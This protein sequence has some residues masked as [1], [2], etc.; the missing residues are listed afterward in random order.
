MVGYGE[1]FGKI[2]GYEEKPM[3]CIWERRKMKISLKT[4]E[5]V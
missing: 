2:H 1:K 5:Y 3:E 4:V